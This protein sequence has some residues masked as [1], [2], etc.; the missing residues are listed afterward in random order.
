MDKE[1]F[2]QFNIRFGSLALGKHQLEVE[3]NN[4]F[5]EKYK[6]DDIKNGDIRVNIKLERKESMVVLNFDLR[7]NIVSFCD[8]CLE[9]LTI[10]IA[11]QEI[12]ILKTTG[13]ARE[14]DNENIVFVGEK[15]NFYNIEQLLYE[16]IVTSIPIRKVHQEMGT[17]TCNPDMLKRIEK[18]KNES[19]SQEDER[20]NVLKEIKFE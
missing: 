16:Y 20:W 4:I 14:S 19:Y 1:Y 10:P 7:G 15:E 3:I 2:K 13:T 6:N 18:A 5:F 11:K 17:E 12:L 9:D 8:V